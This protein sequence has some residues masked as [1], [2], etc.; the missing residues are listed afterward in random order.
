MLIIKGLEKS[1]NVFLDTEGKALIN[2]TEKVKNVA[3]IDRKSMRVRDIAFINTDSFALIHGRKDI[4]TSDDLPLGFWSLGLGP[5]FCLEDPDYR[6][7][8]LPTGRPHVDNG[9]NL[10][11]VGNFASF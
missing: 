2:S 9:I 1:N 10:L 8:T 5:P 7:C 6:F 3:V 11:P 4:S